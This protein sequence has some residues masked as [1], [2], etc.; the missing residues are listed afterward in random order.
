MALIYAMI[1][2]IAVLI[3]ATVYIPANLKRK[4]LGEEVKREVEE[5]RRYVKEQR[6]EIRRKMEEEGFK[7]STLSIWTERSYKM[8]E[9]ICS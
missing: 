3:L 6:A 5:G 1:S 4:R 7:G 2:Y 8:L 9:W